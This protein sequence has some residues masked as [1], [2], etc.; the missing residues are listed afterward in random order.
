MDTVE[1][2]MEKEA[3]GEG[4][5]VKVSPVECLCAYIQI[6]RTSLRRHDFVV[7]INEMKN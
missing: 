5:L 1:F 4:R 2:I 6:V 7:V 3:N